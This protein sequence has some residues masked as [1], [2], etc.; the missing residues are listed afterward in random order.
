[1]GGKDGG[2]DKKT[3]QHRTSD[4]FRKRSVELMDREERQSDATGRREWRVGWPGVQH[5]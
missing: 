1:M 5:A 4:Y 2:K 3:P